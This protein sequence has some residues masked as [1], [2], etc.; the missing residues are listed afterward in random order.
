[1]R[2]REERSDGAATAAAAAAAVSAP[3]EKS[4]RMSTPLQMSTATS[5]GEEKQPKRQHQ[6]KSEG[7]AWRT[8]AMGSACFILL[9]MFVKKTASAGRKK[10][11]LASAGMEASTNSR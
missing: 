9:L 10:S 1:M 7:K 6:E 3:L 4:R 5:Q 11:R 8:V 2:G